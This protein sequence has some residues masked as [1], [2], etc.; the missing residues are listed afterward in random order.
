MQAM[1][2]TE[3][4]EFRRSDPA[5]FTERLRRNGP[6]AVAEFEAAKALWARRNEG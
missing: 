1:Y 6:S 3:Q 5:Q 2:E 4:L